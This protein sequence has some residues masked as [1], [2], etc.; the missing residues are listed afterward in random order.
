MKKKCKICGDEFFNIINLGK[1]PCADTFLKNRSKSLNLRKVFLKVGFCQCSH[2]TALY[3]MPEKERYQRYDYSYTSDNSPVSRNHFKNIAKTICKKF[4]L[5]KN[6]LVVE[7]GSNDGTFLS[8]IK[9][10]SK[11]RTV[12]IDPSPNMNKLANKKKFKLLL[13]FLTKRVH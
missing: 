3:K 10:F 12:G 4:N 1:H 7:A 6:N 11:A 9:K 2:M 13:S 8:E 5:K